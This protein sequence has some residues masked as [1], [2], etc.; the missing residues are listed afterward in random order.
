MSVSSMH[1]GLGPS[2]AAAA[3]HAR[4][5]SFQLLTF[6][7]TFHSFSGSFVSGIAEGAP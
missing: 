4:L 6:V 7:S 2:A 5:G 1:G 3:S